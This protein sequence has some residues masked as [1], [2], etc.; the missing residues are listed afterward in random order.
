MCFQWGKLIAP[1]SNESGQYI[2]FNV[3]FT[4]VYQVV[5]TC[6]SSSAL[7]LNGTTTSKEYINAVAVSIYN[8]TNNG[9]YR[10]YIYKDSTYTS[11]IAVGKLN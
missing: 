2:P 4:A 5:T 10:N 3:T 6:Y 11:W 7:S 8:K 9:F 1:S